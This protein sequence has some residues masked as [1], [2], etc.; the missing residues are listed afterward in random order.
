MGGQSCLWSFEKFWIVEC[1]YL[2]YDNTDIIICLIATVTGWLYNS[3]IEHEHIY[4]MHIMLSENEKVF[5]LWVLL[6]QPEGPCRIH[7]HPVFI[8]QKYIL[9]THPVND[10]SVYTV[11][12]SGPMRWLRHERNKLRFAA[13]LFFRSLLQSLQK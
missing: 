8:I 7:K 1:H 3:I 12:Q 10:S 2:N 6:N 9:S 4:N 5:T 11:N 13:L